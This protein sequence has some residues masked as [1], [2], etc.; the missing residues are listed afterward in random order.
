M[1]IC[2]I[3]KLEFDGTDK[4]YIGQSADIV[5]RFKEHLYNL[6]T[7]IASAK[8]QNGFKQY[9]IP[10]LTILS[11]CT[12]EELEEQEQES[13]EIYNSVNNGFNSI[14]ITDRV[15]GLQ[16]YNHGSCI[17]TEKELVAILTYLVNYPN[18]SYKEI[19]SILQVSINTVAQ[20]AGL[21]SHIWLKDK[22]P[23][24]YSILV[25]LKNTRNKINGILEDKRS[26]GSKGKVYKVISPDNTIHS[27]SNIRAFCRDNNLHNGCVTEVLSGKRKTHKGW[28]LCPEELV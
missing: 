8:L 19:S 9:G 21:R 6:A 18:F 2:G 25:N 4:V 7:G 24:M 23:E 1:T 12:S 5:R 10:K 13:I 15:V 17:H 28:R 22:Y 27:V 16:G 14:H 11:E 20:I 26:N 3:Y